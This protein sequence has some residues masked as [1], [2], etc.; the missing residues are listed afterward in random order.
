MDSLQVVLFLVALVIGG[1]DSYRGM[2][3]DENLLGPEVAAYM[4]NISIAYAFQGFVIN[5][6][7]QQ[8]CF[9]QELDIS[10]SLYDVKLKLLQDNR[11]KLLQ[12][13]ID[14]FIARAVTTL[15]T[16]MKEMLLSGVIDAR[17]F[18]FEDMQKMFHRDIGMV[19]WRQSIYSIEAHMMYGLSTIRPISCQPVNARIF[20]EICYPVVN[21]ADMYS[22]FRVTHRG[23]FNTDSSVFGYANVADHIAVPLHNESGQNVGS[24]WTCRGLTSDHYKYC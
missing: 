3:Y 1:G 16:Y 9:E 19:R 21:K 17:V 14:Q 24:A 8:S 5:L 12:Y 23:A 10:L 22:L 2:E 11:T 15:S 13:E 4:A 20:V 7:H 18:S 6:P